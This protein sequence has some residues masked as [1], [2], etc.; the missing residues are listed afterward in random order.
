MPYEA[1]LLF[2]TPVPLL[3]GRNVAPVSHLI[4]HKVSP[5]KVRE[6]AHQAYLFR[7][8]AGFANARL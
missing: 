4:G 8:Y 6:D 5:Q 2:A 1:T 3:P 7:L